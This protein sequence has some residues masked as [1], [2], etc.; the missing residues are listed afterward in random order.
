M[1]ETLLWWLALEVIGLAGL[2]LTVL[3]FA[4]LPDRGW[5]LAKPFS[6]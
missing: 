6:L 5:S 3:V 4:N 2:P 1:S